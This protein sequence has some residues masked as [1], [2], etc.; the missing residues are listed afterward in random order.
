LDAVTVTL[1]VKLPADCAH[2]PPNFQTTGVAGATEGAGEL[3]PFDGP[4][5]AAE[6]AEALAA[7]DARP[8]LDPSDEG[9]DGPEAPTAESALPVTDGVVA[10]ALGAVVADGS[11][12][13]GETGAAGKVNT[14]V[15]LGAGGEA[16]TRG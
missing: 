15:A 2:A 1:Q 14:V 16:F 5:G 7:S 4:D 11:I 13:L 3:D 12:G 8:A 6:G 9:A 10:W